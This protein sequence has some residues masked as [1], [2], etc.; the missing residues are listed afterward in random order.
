[1]AL[2]AVLVQPSAIIGVAMPVLEGEARD[3]YV[4]VRGQKYYDSYN[5]THPEPP[6]DVRPHGIPDKRFL[7]VWRMM[8]HTMHGGFPPTMRAGEPS[9][10]EVPDF[11]HRPEH[12]VESVFWSFYAALSRVQPMDGV[13]EKF[14][15]DTLHNAWS[16]FA[17]HKIPHT[18]DSRN[19]DSR[20]LILDRNED[21]WVADFRPFPEMHDL[22][23]M[24]HKLALQ[25]RPEYALWEWE[26]GEPKPDHLHEACQR[27]I[28]QYLVKHR[29]HDIAL[30]PT[31]LRPVNTPRPPSQHG[32]VSE[33]NNDDGA[34]QVQPRS[35]ESKKVP[36]QPGPAKGKAPAATPRAKS[37]LT[38]A[39]S[40]DQKNKS[41]PAS[42]SSTQP[43]RKSARV[44]SSTGNAQAAPK[45]ST[46]KGRLSTTTSA[47]S[48]RGSSK[49]KNEADDAL[50][51]KRIR[52]S[53]RRNDDLGPA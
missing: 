13:R 36:F 14:V 52:G 31:S 47:Q 45:P 49:R 22:G 50:P 46:P 11:R 39:A 21:T 9:P 35:N 38:K 2:G 51:V 10:K 18:S 28:L 19:Q 53:R 48:Q 32:T 27:I 26:D 42:G 33:E 12:D 1:M 41:R 7:S 23:R 30:D 8:S 3:L 5:D 44:A 15:P 17:A 16:L 6:E 25:V 40:S 37:H 29:D 20:I 34:P 43:T 24:L 4:R